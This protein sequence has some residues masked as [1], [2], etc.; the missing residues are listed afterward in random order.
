MGLETFL[1]FATESEAI[2][3]ARADELREE[4]WKAL[5]EVAAAQAEHQTAE[6]PTQ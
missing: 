4:G 6:E 2:T 3:V 5:G 1:E